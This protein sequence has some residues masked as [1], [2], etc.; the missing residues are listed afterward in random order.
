VRQLLAVHRAIMVVDVEGFGDPARTNLDQLAVRE[1]LYEALARAF[2]ESGI[3]WGSCVSED[4]G[5]GALILI[6]PEPPIHLM[7]GRA[8]YSGPMASI[9]RR[10][11]CGHFVL[12]HDATADRR[13]RARWRRPIRP[14]AADADSWSWGWGWS[15]HVAG[16]RQALSGFSLPFQRAG[17]LLNTVP[18]PPVPAAGK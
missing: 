8:S 16:W 10:V 11:E 3:G 7:T 6:P 9:A 13:H 1:A 4:R 18:V 17:T 15:I 2:A 12:V 14:E 5:D